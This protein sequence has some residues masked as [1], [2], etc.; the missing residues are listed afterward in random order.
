MV[1]NQAV[2]RLRRSP[3]DEVLADLNA[4]YAVMVRSGRIER[5]GA[6]PVE[7]SSD[8]VPELPRLVWEFNRRDYGALRR[9][10]DD[11]NDLVPAGTDPGSTS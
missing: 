2:L 1:G 3:S 10:I 6:L 5:S 8:D 11:L 7:R 9:M 4:R